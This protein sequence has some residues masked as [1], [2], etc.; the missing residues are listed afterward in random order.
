ME[1]DGTMADVKML[2][3][4]TSKGSPKCFSDVLH[5][6]LEGNPDLQ[7]VVLV[8]GGRT[9]VTRPFR[10]SGGWR[11][12]SGRPTKSALQGRPQGHVV[13]ESADGRCQ[14]FSVRCG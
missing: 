8:S 9:G 11:R 12:R 10:N 4:C 5:N 1:C 7:L 6:I 13:R 2:P 3:A 14:F